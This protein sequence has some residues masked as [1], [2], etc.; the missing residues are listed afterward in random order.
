M[1]EIYALEEEYMHPARAILQICVVSLVTL[2]L[3]AF[4]CFNGRAIFL[5]TLKAEFSWMQCAYL[6]I[7]L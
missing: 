2:S 4:Y 7:Q 3:F 1:L 6:S 5:K